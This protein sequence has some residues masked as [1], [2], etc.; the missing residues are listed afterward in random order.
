MPWRRRYR[1]SWG[2][3]FLR[4][5]GRRRYRRH[6]RRPWR[7]YR[8]RR[9]R[10]VY[11]TQPRKVTP[12]LVQGWEIL[13]VQ[14]AQLEFHYLNNKWDIHI[15]NAAPSNKQVEYFSKTVPPNIN[16]TCEDKWQSGPKYWD[17][18]GGW[19][20]AKFDL[21]SLVL[22]N[23]LG[24][25]RFSEDI[26]KYTHI[27]F[28]GLK[29]QL[30]RAMDLD[31]LFR[32]QMHRGPFDYETSL[33]HP[34][35]LLNMP[36]VKWVQSI[37]RSNCCK[38]PTIRRR[39]PPDLSGWFDIETFRNYELIT[40]QW[41]VFDPNN[42][43]GRNT[44]PI[45]TTEQSKFFDD[46]WMRPS[47]NKE[48]ISVN[49]NDR[50]RWADRTSYDSQFVGDMNNAAGH[51][52]PDSNLFDFIWDKINQWNQND[53]GFRK[54]KTTPFLP[55]MIESPQVNTF[56]FRYRFYFLLGGS[57]ISRNLQK[58]PIRETE[59]DLKPCTG[60]QG[61]PACI[62]EGDLDPFGVLTEKALKR[63]TEPPEHRKKKLVEKLA[64]LIR[65]RRKR[66]RVT[67]WDETTTRNSPTHSNPKKKR[68]RDLRYLASSLRF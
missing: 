20:Q 11:Q 63:I 37:T 28:K 15:R 16:N 3:H 57:T 47:S 5:R 50:V 42:P 43:M 33:I 2:R 1:R 46:D 14:G 56:W 9:V 6:W 19:G 58:W 61:C 59:D 45:G 67:W 25:N 23:L 30:I 12:L 35:H 38:S 41:T 34:A 36:W 4:H 68:L 22:R 39:T 44:T 8:K 21:Q 18:V 26:R 48:T 65:H 60:H 40:Y 64:K 52:A 27:K 51:Q 49:L 55:P 17:F 53:K 62:H 66:K 29:F 13:G 31:Y 24:F 32:P 7:R 10:K 54:G